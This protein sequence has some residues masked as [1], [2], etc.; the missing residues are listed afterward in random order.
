MSAA[1]GRS[2]SAAPPRA[3]RA[4]R[5]DRQAAA[6]LGAALPD[7]GLA[8]WAAQFGPAADWPEDLS[9]APL[10]IDTDIGGD[11]DDTLAVAAAARMIPELALVITCAETGPPRPGQRAM[12]ARHL[13]DLAGRPDV[14][15]AEGATGPGGDPYWQAGEIVPAGAPRQPADVSA[16]VRKVCA[17]ARG[18]VRWVGM[19][20]MSNLA[21]LA[22]AEPRL[23]RRL[24]VT[25]MG[26]AVAYRDPDRG[27]HNFRLDPAAVQAVLRA[28]A[29]R[30]QPAIELVTSDV[31]WTPQ[32]EVTAA[33]S[34]Y[35]MLAAAPAGSWAGLAAAHLD[36]WFTACHPG[37]RQHDALALTA[38]LGL[39]FVTSAPARVTVD[40]TGRMTRAVGGAPVLL[41]VSARHAAFMRWLTAALDP[42][43]VLAVP[44]AARG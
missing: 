43:R 5:R 12:L 23:F 41:S 31:T 24:R 29:G 38:A 17:A 30:T 27:E 36:R 34:L 33:S 6:E 32:I 35:R 16:A 37:S 40:E 7:T 44:A 10:I 39:P 4:L 18:P 15:V 8:G 21:R 1:P 42:A 13:L 2:R 20:P 3:V 14:P 11:P 9:R 25:Q 26:G 19:G 28:A 22:S